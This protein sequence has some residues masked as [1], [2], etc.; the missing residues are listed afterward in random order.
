MT[1]R[2]RPYNSGKALEHKPYVKQ[3]NRGIARKLRNSA[4]PLR[5]VNSGS[6][7]IY[8]HNVFKII[9][10]L[11]STDRDLV[12]RAYEYVQR[13][14][15]GQKRKSGKTVVSHLINTALI[16]QEKMEIKDAELLAA[17]LL[18]DVLEDSNVKYEELM[19]KFGR[20]VADLVFAET[21]LSEAMERE[22]RD[23]ANFIRLFKSMSVDPRVAL[24]KAAD[25]LDNMMDQEV[26]P[27]DKR[28]EHADEAMLYASIME[29]MRVWEMRTCLEDRAYRY[30]EPDIF[31]VLRSFALNRIESAGQILG[32]FTANVKMLLE[33]NGIEGVKVEVHQRAISEL[34]R[35]MERRNLNFE[36][37]FSQNPLYM[38]FVLIEID[39]Q[40]AQECFR[41]LNILRHV[42]NKDQLDGY[43]RK[44]EKVVDFMNSPRTD[45]YRALQTKMYRPGEFGDLLVTIT[46]KKMNDFNRFGLAAVGRKYDFY[47][48]WHRRVDFDWL[49]DLGDEI[50]RVTSTE[51]V[52]AQVMGGSDYI[53]VYT[54]QGE[55]IELRRGSTV[56]DFAYSIH[57][58]L[59]FEAVGALINRKPLKESLFHRLKPGDVI[60]IIKGDGRPSVVWLEHMLSPSARDRL[61]RYL[62]K[63][64]GREAVLDAMYALDYEGGKYQV[65]AEQL[66]ETI[67]F[68]RYLAER[69]GIGEADVKELGH[70]KFK[71]ISEIGKGEISAKEVVEGMNDL[72]LEA[73]SQLTDK[74]K[75][76]EQVYIR[77]RPMD[78][79]GLVAQLGEAIHEQGFNISRLEVAGAL[80][81]DGRGEIVLGVDV[82]RGK[83]M[84][85]GDLIGQ[86]QR[87]QVLTIAKRFDEGAHYDLRAGKK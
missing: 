84:E 58:D 48:G 23:L 13:V 69:F 37:V 32:R 85:G 35:K 53:R 10:G 7:V 28:I 47:P 43:I 52:R 45:G 42:A 73:L 25:C 64:E 38:S 63:R 62:N 20:G 21:K 34:F 54:P 29:G 68:N 49:K 3:L 11:N 70:L 71:L 56:L 77:L 1:T 86:V 76:L 9:Q 50:K 18:H 22:A 60:K 15:K 24:L 39:H 12:L 55:E 46:T 78:R 17:G 16:L 87:I 67:L 57:G 59:L 5:V 74:K 65:N 4:Y 79:K 44:D 66:V 8:P 80:T 19:A 41:V 81:E 27:P 51:E 30:Y 2:I 26:F 31:N 6:V 75:M 83:N 82:I 72:Y 14:F 33:V 40:D 36:E 61:R